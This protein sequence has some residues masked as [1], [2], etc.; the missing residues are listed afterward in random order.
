[1][2]EDNSLKVY[3]KMNRIQKKRERKYQLRVTLR[4]FIS[5]FH[6]EDVDKVIKFLNIVF[7]LSRHI[8]SIIIMLIYIV[9]NYKFSSVPLAFGAATL[10]S[11]LLFFYEY[12]PEV[13]KEMIRELTFI[14]INLKKFNLKNNSKLFL[15]K[16]RVLFGNKILMANMF[17]FMTHIYKGTPVWLSALGTAIMSGILVFITIVFLYIKLFKAEGHVPIKGKDQIK[18]LAYRIDGLEYRQSPF[19][20]ISNL[21]ELIHTSFYRSDYKKTVNVLVIIISLLMIT[22]FIYSLLSEDAIN[23][24]SVV[25]FSVYPTILNLFFVRILANAFL[26]D[27]IKY[28]NFYLIKKFNLQKEYD[29]II[30]KVL[31]K[32]TFPIV[33]LWVIFL[34]A[35]NRCNLFSVVLSLLICVQWIVIATILVKRCVKSY[36]YDFDDLQLN[37]NSLAM[38]NVLEDYFL[39]GLPIILLSYLIVLVHRSQS[40]YMFTVFMFLYTIAAVLYLLLLYAIERRGKFVQHK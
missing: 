27:N 38:N 20:R 31:L 32:N 9:I 29:R 28:A 33:S 19:K 2:R 24:I 1:M 11:F 15:Y 13:I 8:G 34:L 4:K 40:L 39:F 21:S 7:E 30:L 17:S 26:S 23:Y 37:L 25:T 22:T 18:S 5:F 12:S 14:N 6:E 36:Q 10:F 35:V 3:A 16:W